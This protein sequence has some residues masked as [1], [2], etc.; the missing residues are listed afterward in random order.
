M[1]KGNAKLLLIIL[2]ACMQCYM[3]SGQDLGNIKQQNP[4]EISGTASA[5]VGYY[6]ANSFNSTRKPYAYSIMLAPTISVYGV[7]IP[8][9]FTF[10]EG[11]RSV[12]NPFAQ[13]GINPYYKWVKGYF[14]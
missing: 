12:S 1:I 14:G 3:L 11:S 10:T 8:L 9:N 4:F 7:Q 5:S 6:K 13:F 2:F